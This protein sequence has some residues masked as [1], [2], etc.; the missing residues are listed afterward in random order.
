LTATPSP[1]RSRTA[2]R[3]RLTR[4]RRRLPGDLIVTDSDGAVV[5]PHHRAGWAADQVDR[6]M[7]EEALRRR[8]LAA[9]GRA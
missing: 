7:E 5:V 2:P 4:H 6:V 3:D 1:A 9:R 8:I